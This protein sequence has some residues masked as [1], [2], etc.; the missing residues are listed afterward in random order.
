MLLEIRETAGKP[1]GFFARNQSASAAEQRWFWL[2]V[3]CR[4]LNHPFLISHWVET[5][6]VT[7]PKQGLTIN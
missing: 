6:K 1:A 7:P 3:K 5:S 4:Y 2:E